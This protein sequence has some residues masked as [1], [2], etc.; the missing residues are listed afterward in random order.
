MKHIAP[1]AWPLAALAAILLTS[2]PSLAG[3]PSGTGQPNQSC[4]SPTATSSPKGFGTKGFTHATTVYAGSG[5]SA[6]R[7]KSTEA[8]SQYDVACFHHTQNAPMTRRSAA[9]RP[10]HT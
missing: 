8:V 5:K 7:S 1:A 2:A 6:T 10:R 9:P 4:G 3:N